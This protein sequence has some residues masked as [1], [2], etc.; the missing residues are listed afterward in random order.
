MPPRARSHHALRGLFLIILLAWLPGCVDF[1]LVDFSEHSFPPDF[2][3]LVRLPNAQGL[4]A[5]AW[6]ARLHQAAAPLLPAG[7]AEAL[8]TDQ[9]ATAG[10][11]A[12]VWARFNLH[13]EDLD[14]LFLNTRG[15]EQS[16]QTVSPTATISNGRILRPAWDGFH[17]VEV[18]V[19]GN[20]VLYARLGIPE[21]QY[22]IPGSF[23]I[24]THGLFG[25]LD[26]KDVINHVQTLRRAGHHV[27]AIEMRGHGQTHF[28]H[29]EYGITFG[30]AESGDFLA[31]ARWLKQ[32]QG[33]TRVG[34]V[35]FSL[36]GFEALLTAWLDG[37]APVTELANLP[38]NA[39]LP[40][41]Q[42]EPA[43]NGGM[44]IISAPVGILDVGQRFEPH[45]SLLE[46]PVKATF[47]EHISQRIASYKL[48]SG[49]TMWDLARCEFPRGDSYKLYPS[50]EAA[51]TDL[52]A[53][54]DVSREDWKV[55]AARMENIR[56]PV[57]VLNA[58]NDPLAC[59]QGVADLFSR[60]HN[61]NIGVI[62]LKEGGHIGFTAYGADYYYSLMM[63]FFDPATAPV[64]SGPS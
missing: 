28:N 37:T 62:I 57:L 36:T 13:P 8:T 26:G 60:Q 31:A 44:F 9:L 2:K 12:D 7:R 53:F 46:A 33:A 35:T 29:P 59:A 51:R 1:R 32:T 47:Q 39:V 41:H 43:F 64:I 3:R 19:P 42:A 5:R 16:A 50:F 61:P 40:R 58:A 63:N 49:Y 15:I 14:N 11:P 25:T 4:P 54:L 17:E 56:V 34:L 30:I 24:I 10:G 27:L 22:E 21:K 6:A 52:M 18:P 38:L 20:A 48:G 23:V 45:V 55:G